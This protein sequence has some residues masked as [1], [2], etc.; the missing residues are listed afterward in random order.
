MTSRGLEDVPD[1]RLVRLTD[2][3]AATWMLPALGALII[4]AIYLR[5][6][7]LPSIDLHGPLHRVGI[8]DPLCG[9][10]RATYLLVRGDLAGAWSWNPLVPILGGAAA[11]GLARA[12]AGWFSGRWL[13]VGLPRRGWI[14]SIGLL[15]VVIEI[16]QQLQADRLMHAVPT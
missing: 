12:V 9:G 13:S 5:I 8:M 1:R 10:T 3:D 4:G 6:A 11:L 2:R 7:G 15:L 14:S 16:N